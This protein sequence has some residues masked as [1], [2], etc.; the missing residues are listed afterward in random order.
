MAGWR[1]E[2]LGELVEEYKY[3]SVRELGQKL[4]EILDGVLPCFEEEVIVVP[5]PTLNRHI[6]ERGLDHT[7][8][9]AKKLARMRGWQV[10]KILVRTGTNVQVGANRAER[11][12]Q[13]SEA[14]GLKEDARIDRN[15]LYLMVDDVWTTGASMEAAARIIKKAGARKLAAAVLVIGRDD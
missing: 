13:A 15:K 3:Q 12:K 8:T 2:K 11:I 7:Y 1:D 10:E 9:I 4:A 6:R 5:L 14:Y